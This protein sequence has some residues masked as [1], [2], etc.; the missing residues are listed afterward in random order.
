MLPQCWVQAM[1]A[2][3]V[4]AF[5]IHWSMVKSYSNVVMTEASLPWTS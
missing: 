1:A 2:M 3:D 5:D 4:D